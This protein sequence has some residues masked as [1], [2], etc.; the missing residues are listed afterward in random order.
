MAIQMIS[1]LP[2]FQITKD[3]P[4][5]NILGSYMEISYLQTDA[6]SGDSHTSY[7]SMAIPL[8]TLYK[9]MTSSSDSSEGGIFHFPGQC[10]MTDGL[11]ISGDISVNVGASNM[12]KNLEMKM[13]SVKL[14]SFSNDISTRNHTLNTESFQV[15]D[16]NQEAA[17]VNYVNNTV[18]FGAKVSF[19]GGVTCKT[20]TETS[21]ET[22]VNLS[23][24]N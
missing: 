19:S 11:E 9:A 21:N 24:L 2:V 7:K 5:H 8:G 20:P 16:P 22:V 23:I 17:V 3:T 1:D 15:K 12:L 4:R 18:N 10:V 14:S 6:N 13:Q